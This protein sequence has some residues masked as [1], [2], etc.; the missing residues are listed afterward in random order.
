M[1]TFW[2][3]NHWNGFV[4][5]KCILPFITIAKWQ[6]QQTYKMH[7]TPCCCCCCCCF[8]FYFSFCNWP[9]TKK[10]TTSPYKS[11]SPSS[12]LHHSP[13]LCFSLF[14]FILVPNETFYDVPNAEIEFMFYGNRLK[15][16]H[17]VYI[18]KFVYVCVCVSLTTSNQLSYVRK[19]Y[20]QWL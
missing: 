7:N 19:L 5:L 3:V 20:S 18:V 2:C 4:T 16:D 15:P 9:C 8:Y 17:N 13:F 12:H 1:I 14:F 10:I 11:I 6:T